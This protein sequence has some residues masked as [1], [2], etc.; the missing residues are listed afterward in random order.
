VS[1]FDDPIDDLEGLAQ[2]ADELLDRAIL[3]GWPNDEMGITGLEVRF[4][5][6][7]L[8]LVDYIDELR[9]VIRRYQGAQ[10]LDD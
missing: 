1:A 5:S 6:G 3:M 7:I 8:L 9:A 2:D 4:A 10:Y